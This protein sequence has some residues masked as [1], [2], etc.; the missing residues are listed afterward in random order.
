MKW[1]VFEKFKNRKIECQKKGAEKFEKTNSKESNAKISKN[2]ILKNPKI[3][4][5]K[6]ENYYIFSSITYLI[7]KASHIAIKSWNQRKENL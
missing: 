2:Q 6:V 3:K 5:R 7:F 4:L 1:W